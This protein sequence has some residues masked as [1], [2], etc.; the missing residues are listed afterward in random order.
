ME[1]F[2]QTAPGL[3]SALEAELR[4][5]G[6]AGA[7]EPGG[8][9]LEADLETVALLGLRL[10]TASRVLVTVGRFRASALAELE[11]KAG[12]L[13]WDRFLPG[14]HD[15]TFRVTC[16]KSRL[17]HTGAVAE[18]LTRGAG[19]DPSTPSPHTTP[20]VVRIV[21]DRVVVRA[22]ASG[23]HL[24]R[25]GYRRATARAPIRETL[26]AGILRLAEWSPESPLVDPLCGSGTFVVEAALRACRR[27]PGENRTFALEA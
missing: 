20:F 9:V 15:P 19:R 17:Y 25:R 16:R 1:V 23:V 27:A 12:G 10:A 11:R 8:V 13:P 21:R 18:R 14:D 26:A 7:V 5:L 4:E 6:M 24:H 3:E 22:D 2:V